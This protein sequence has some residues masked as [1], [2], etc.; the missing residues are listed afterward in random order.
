MIQV[1]NSAQ[2]SM[3][4]PP[5]E[6]PASARLLHIRGTSEKQAEYRQAA[7]SEDLTLAEWARRALDKAVK[8]A[9]RR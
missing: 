1:M 9:R 3:Y 5:I 4:R 7:E 8:A 2:K 6:N